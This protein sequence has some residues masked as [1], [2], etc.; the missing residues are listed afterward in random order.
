MIYFMPVCE[1]CGQPASR[2][3]TWDEDKGVTRIN[4]YCKNHIPKSKK[5]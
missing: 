3:I 5:S 4:Y 1:K 2:S